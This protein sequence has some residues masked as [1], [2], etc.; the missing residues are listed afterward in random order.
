M[1]LTDQNFVA[2]FGDTTGINLSHQ[3]EA[4]TSNVENKLE[5]TDGQARSLAATKEVEAKTIKTEPIYDIPSEAVPSLE[6]TDPAL[7]IQL[8]V[9]E[10]QALLDLFRFCPRCGHQLRE[11]G[12][13][14]LTS[15]SN[16]T[17]IVNYICDM[18]SQ[19]SSTSQPSLWE[20]RKMDDDMIKH[21][22]DL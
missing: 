11:K 22:V 7:K 18:C 16:S 12:A 21:E 2:M 5:S 8:F 19:Q 17:P 15:T 14:Q 4:G 9:V 20:G 3:C 13:V 1:L 10:G 6:E